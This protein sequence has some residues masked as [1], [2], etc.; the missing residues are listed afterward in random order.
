MLGFG[1]PRAT[2]ISLT[3]SP[4]HQV[5]ARKLSRR[6]SATAPSGY[7]PDDSGRA[8]RGDAA[9][10]GPRGRQVILAWQGEVAR[11]G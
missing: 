6:S 1:H 7:G 3:S 5:R 10:L 4:E 9:G 11:A 8:L 2:K